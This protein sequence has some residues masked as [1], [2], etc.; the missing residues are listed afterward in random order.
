MDVKAAYRVINILVYNILIEHQI[1]VCAVPE[2]ELHPNYSYKKC[3][4]Q[5]LRIIDS[6]MSNSI[7]DIYLVWLNYIIFRYFILLTFFAMKRKL[8]GIA[9]YYY[10]C[11]FS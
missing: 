4:E 10:Y 7:V 9:K 6:Y 1:V 8:C 11:G 5:F 3:L 2:T